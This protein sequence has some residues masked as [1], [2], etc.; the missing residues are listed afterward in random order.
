MAPPLNKV[1][2]YIWE[3]PKTYKQCMRVPVRVFA[4]A[5]SSRR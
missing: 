4:T 1:S 5:R 3:I 2:D